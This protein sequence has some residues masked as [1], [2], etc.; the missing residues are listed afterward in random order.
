MLELKFELP[1]EKQFQIA[2]IDME[3]DSVTE[4]QVT[5]DML[6]ELTRLCIAREHLSQQLIKHI[7]VIELGIGN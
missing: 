7:A 3:I 4:L 5:K 2:Q 6:K 1:V